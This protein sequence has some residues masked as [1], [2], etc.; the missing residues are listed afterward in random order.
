LSHY[1]IYISN[2]IKVREVFEVVKNAF[3]KLVY[4]RL[5]YSFPLLLHI[6]GKTHKLCFA[7]KD[8]DFTDVQF[9]Q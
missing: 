6:A 7:E 8:A 3:G 9:D 1:K 5:E 4:S 2:N